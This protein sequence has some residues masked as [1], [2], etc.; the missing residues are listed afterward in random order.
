MTMP[1]DY[2]DDPLGIFKALGVRILFVTALGED[3]LLLE[4]HG[5]ALADASLS[6]SEVADLLWTETYRFWAD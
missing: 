4:D 2:I 3:L 1:L 5:I 6:R